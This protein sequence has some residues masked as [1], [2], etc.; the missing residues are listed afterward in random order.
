[1]PAE[2]LSFDLPIRVAMGAADFVVSGSNRDAVAWLDRWPEWPGSILAIHGPAG[3]GKTH[4]AHVWRMR[5]QATFL[6][7]Q[8]GAPHGFDRLPS[9][10]HFILDGLILDG[11]AA[12]EE[13]L[14][15]LI[16][17]VRAYRL[18]LLILDRE[19][20]ARWPVRLPDLASRLAALPSIAVEAPDDALL[21]AILDKHFSDRQIRVTPEVV[22]YL[23]RRIE[24]SFAAAAAVAAELD[25]LALSRG[26]AIS[27]KLAR[28][29]FEKAPPDAP[30]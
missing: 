5:S 24:R 2:Q 27:I 29:I 14:F 6:D 20:P 12:A 8:S 25:R 13:D 18:S 23:V 26:A 16:N 17:H 21:G 15:H 9:E 1:M 11:R 30:L 4:L 28:E 22:A 10:G 19:A 3:G 7:L